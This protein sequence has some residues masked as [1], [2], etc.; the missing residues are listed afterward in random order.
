MHLRDA[1]PD[2]AP[3]IAARYAEVAFAPTDLARDRVVVAERD[4][5]RVGLGRL[6]RL[7]PGH[8]ELGGIVV[9]EGARKGGVARA[10][11]MRLLDM[12]RGETVWCIPW[13]RLAGFYVSCG[14]PRVPDDELARVPAGVQHKLDFCARTYDEPVTLLR[15]AP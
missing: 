8:V 12:A 14:L 9:V 5:A 2:D 7:E 15:R 11:V 13:T 10:I 3:W 4:G 6:V 1:T